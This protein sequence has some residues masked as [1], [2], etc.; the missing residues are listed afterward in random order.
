[1]ACSGENGERGRPMILFSANI[2]LFSPFPRKRA[3][4]TAERGRKWYFVVG[5]D[6]DINISP[7]ASPGWRGRGC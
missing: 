2:R 5:A 4:N 6:F 1:M 7:P 3:L